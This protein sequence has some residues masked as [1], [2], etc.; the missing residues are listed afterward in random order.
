MLALYINNKITKQYKT[1]NPQDS[2]SHKPQNIKLDQYTQPDR[3]L[4]YRQMRNVQ[5]KPSKNKI[6][7]SPFWPY[8]W[9]GFFLLAHHRWR[10]LWSLW[11]PWRRLHTRVSNI[12]QPPKSWEKKTYVRWRR[13][14]S[15]AIWRRPV[16]RTICWAVPGWL[17]KV[18]ASQLVKLFRS[19][20]GKQE[21]LTAGLEGTLA[22]SRFRPPLGAFGGPPLLDFRAAFELPDG[23]DSGRFRFPEPLP[24]FLKEDWDF[25]GSGFGG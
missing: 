6:Q 18:L 9:I 17:D 14:L 2:S 8:K 11:R 5:N 13:P 10:R 24:S 23:G 7:S 19:H 1:E 25:L 3:S 21:P 16:N 12:K 22:S 20:G 15:W 4:V